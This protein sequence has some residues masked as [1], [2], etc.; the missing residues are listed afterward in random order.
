MRKSRRREIEE[1]EQRM[2]DRDINSNS[3]MREIRG[4]VMEAEQCG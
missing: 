1:G 3:E 4:G 2:A